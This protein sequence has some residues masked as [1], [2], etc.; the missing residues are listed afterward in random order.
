MFRKNIRKII[1]KDLTDISCP[2]KAVNNFTNTHCESIS[3]LVN[4]FMPEGSKNLVKTRKK[5]NENFFENYKNSES[6]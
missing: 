3:F 5:E 2:I 6:K 4:D 1:C